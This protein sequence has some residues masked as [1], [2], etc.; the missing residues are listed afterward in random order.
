MHFGSIV[1]A[2]GSYLDAK[3]SNG[4][5]LLR[6]DD[7]DGPRTRAGASTSIKRS[8]EALGLHWDG[9]IL[10]QSERFE[11]YE[12]ALEFL[13]Q[14]NLL[15][16]CYCSRKDTRTLPYPGT[17]RDKPL[18][19]NRQHAL[20]L[21]VDNGET[22]LA[23]LLQGSFVLNIAQ[24]SG[25]FIVRRADDIYAYHLAVVVDDAFQEISHVVRGS[26]LLSSGPAQVYLQGKLGIKTPVYLH[27]PVVLGKDG[28][29][30][31]KTDGAE[32][33]L[34]LLEPAQVL[35]RALEFLGQ[36]TGN[37][38]HS[39]EVNEILQWAVS[40]WNRDRIPR[41]SGYLDF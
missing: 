36:L 35:T 2:L 5:W 30:V 37:F 14:T 17:C 40:N 7:L 28:R 15:Y 25:D 9:E 29:K 8:L 26:D 23:D 12:A 19:S 34:D 10:L 3:A 21:R 31:S 33:I 6:I 39:A 4:K 38:P 18:D 27:L 1:A 41:A 13:Q 16:P 20:R 11:A 22:E 24:D 32:N